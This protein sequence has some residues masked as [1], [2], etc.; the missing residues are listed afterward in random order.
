MLFA[1]LSKEFESRRLL[2]LLECNVNDNVP[3]G[4]HFELL[5]IEHR[6][7]VCARQREYV[8]I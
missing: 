3:A 8:V 4:R 1:F 6:S 5:L 7:S 2:I